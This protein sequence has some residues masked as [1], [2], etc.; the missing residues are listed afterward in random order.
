MIFGDP[1]PHSTLTN[2]PID[3]DG[4]E[5]VRGFIIR[6]GDWIEAIKVVTNKK[7]SIW[8]G[9]MESGRTFDLTPPQGYSII[10]I[11]GRYGR[12]CDG[13]GVVYTSESQF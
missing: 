9:E 13:F 3:V 2:I 12:C 8:L 11:Y 6:A 4:G 7:Q 10:G 1:H 5:M